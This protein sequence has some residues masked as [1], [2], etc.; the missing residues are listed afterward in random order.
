MPASSLV[1]SVCAAVV[2]TRP[3]RKNILE[4]IFFKV[5]KGPKKL[6]FLKLSSM[7]TANTPR[8]TVL[9]L[10]RAQPIASP[11]EFMV[12]YSNEVNVVRQIVHNPNKSN[13]KNRILIYGCI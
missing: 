9:I 2:F 10:S 12:G 8:A 1:T 11:L 13:K 6:T 7:A 4:I 3:V 5:T